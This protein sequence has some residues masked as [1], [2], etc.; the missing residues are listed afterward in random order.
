MRAGRYAAGILGVLL[1]VWLAA[2]AP[3][4]TAS[5]NLVSGHADLNSD[6]PEVVGVGDSATSSSSLPRIGDNETAYGARFNNITQDVKRQRLRLDLP[7]LDVMSYENVCTFV[8]L[9]GTVRNTSARYGTKAGSYPPAPGTSSACPAGD[10][11]MEW[12]LKNVPSTA[13]TSL[14]ASLWLVFGAKV[15][16]QSPENS[17]NDFGEMA[18]IRVHTVAFG[19]VPVS[20]TISIRQP[21]SHGKISPIQLTWAA[22]FNNLVAGT[23][24]PGYGRA[25]TGSLQAFFEPKPTIQ[26]DVVVQVSNLDVDGVPVDVGASC[27]ADGELNF[28]PKPGFYWSGNTT[29]GG[30]GEFT[31]VALPSWLPGETTIADF[32]SCSS[33]EGDDLSPL[34]TSMISGADNAIDTELQIPFAS[35]W[36]DKVGTVAC[37]INATPPE[38]G[39][40]PAATKMTELSKQSLPQVLQRSRLLTELPSGLRQQVIAAVQESL[41]AK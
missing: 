20:A 14:T 5:S 10:N 15:W 36:C 9:A 30:A 31:P 37:D 39:V 13:Y 35:V 21:T 11:M 17:A 3:S 2:T 22:S 24:I 33:P 40:A 32:R 18:P 8:A 19:G 27:S 12:I 16:I 4:A 41:S 25:P 26:G 28:S 34:L 7:P 6:Q 38:E 1:L 23:E 29:K